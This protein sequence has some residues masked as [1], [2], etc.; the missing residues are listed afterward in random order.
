MT[1]GTVSPE[2]KMTVADISIANTCI[3]VETIVRKMGWW[4]WEGGSAM[5]VYSKEE[6][7]EGEREERGRRKGGRYVGRGEEGKDK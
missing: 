1:E 2:V 6:R 5:S 4:P 3:T 7:E